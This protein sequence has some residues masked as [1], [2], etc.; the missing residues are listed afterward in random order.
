MAYLARSKK[1]D[2]VEFTRELIGSI[3]EEREKKEQREKEEE[4]EKKE[5][6]EKEEREKKEEREREERERKRA[7]AFE[8]QK[9]EL[10]VR[11]ASAQP[12][13]SRHIPDQPAKIRMH[14]VMPRFN[15][16]E[17]DVSLFLVLFERQAKIM[18][19]LAENQVT[20]LISFL[21][22]DIV[23]LIAREPEEDA[24]KFEYVKALLLQRFKLS[25]EKFRQ[26][27]NK[28][29]KA[30]ESTWY[31]FYYELKNY[32]EGWLN[33]LNVKTFEQLKY[34]MLVDQIKKRTSMEFK[35][36]FMDEWT[37]IIL[38]TEMVKK[39]EDFEDVRKT[40]KSK[41]FA[42][43]TERNNKGQFKPRYENFSKK[44]EH[45][46][47]SKHSDKWNDYRHQ[48]DHRQRED[49]QQRDRFPNKNQDH[50]FDERYR[51]RCFECGSYS[52]FKQ[53]CPRLK[54]NEKINCVSSND[55]L[56]ETY[57]IRGLVN[58]FEMP[59][60]RD[61]GAT[62]DVIS[63]KFVDY[64][65]MTGE[66]VWV[67][68]LLNDHLVCLPLAEVEIKCELG[69]IKTEAA[70]VT[71]DPGR[72][73]LG[74]KTANLFKDKPFLKLEKIN[75]V[76]TRSQRK[77]ST[78][79]DQNKEAEIEQPEEM[80][81]F[82]IDEE[83][84][85]QADEEF[86]EI[87]QLVEVDSK[88]F[89][90][91]Q[92]QSRDLA[93]LLNE[94][95][96]ENSSKP[97]D[98]KIKENGITS[99]HLDIVKTKVRLVRKQIA[100]E[101]PASHES[102]LEITDLPQKRKRKQLVK[103]ESDSE[104]NAITTDGQVS[105]ATDDVIPYSSLG[106]TEDDELM[107]QRTKGDAELK[108]IVAE[109]VE[110]AKKFCQPWREREVVAESCNVPVEC[111][112]NVRKLFDQDCT[113]PFIV[114]YRKN[115]IGSM[116]AEKLRELQAS[117]YEV[118]QVH[119]KVETVLKTIKHEKFDETVAAS[120]LCA[121][122]MDGVELLYAPFEPGGKRTLAE[123]SKQLGL[124][125]LTLQLLE[126]KTSL[127]Q[128]NLQF[129]IKP[130]RGK[131]VIGIDPGFSHGCKIAC[132]SSKGEVLETEKSYST[133]EREC[134]AIIFAVQKLQCYLDGHTK[135]LIMTDHNPF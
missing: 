132:V 109:A 27:F 22:P 38:P 114:M 1:D 60:L 62:V 78:E 44:I 33:G 24:K 11:A 9:L 129:Y 31:D 63:Q 134:A 46:H 15:P 5:Q 102:F 13:E 54:S 119:K 127:S 115:M 131:V 17:D 58:G 47:Y 104:V 128:I 108:K 2:L 96:T 89:F 75:A 61:T 85:P 117:Y 80:T 48:K 91:S 99:G 30:S 100:C 110:K 19:I 94:A 23:Q 101:S 34:L 37:T 10:E 40:I 121:K 28:H 126:Q 53:Q 18:N 88:E 50:S 67:K 16:K 57:T 35:E 43:Q 66:H 69:H 107:P 36:H 21:P 32:L 73:V 98:F 116:Q 130:V 83:I 112:Q 84:L 76:M 52:H 12:V 41:L 113:I 42:T 95:K 26:L 56:L 87:K 135:F 14:D 7:R 68:Y 82:E 97:N 72:Y 86:K 120:F 118:K 90:E 74:N 77:R 39:I 81:H 106:H 64:A 103:I 93:P 59:I 49:A 45:S 6:R 92:H 105:V 55:D 133:T 65:K 8:L 29:Q 79:E 51:P 70:V 71:N 124:E 111:A 4:R 25:A 125:P 122:R 20:Q 3:K 123:R